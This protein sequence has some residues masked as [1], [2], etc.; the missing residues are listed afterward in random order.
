MK[1]IRQHERHVE[2]ITFIHVYVTS[3]RHLVATQV[4]TDSGESC[5]HDLFTATT[6][7]LEAGDDDRISNSLATNAATDRKCRADTKVKR[8][9]IGD[10]AEDDNATTRQVA[11][12]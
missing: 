11:T 8:Q 1:Q 6:S 3:K 4:N 9:R 2:P 12:D 7:K 10:K 5:D